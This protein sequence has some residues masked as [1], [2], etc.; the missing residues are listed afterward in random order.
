MGVTEALIALVIFSTAMLGIV[1]T[2]ARVG[3]SLNSSHVRLRALAI[4][5]HQVEELLSADYDA[6][7]N[8]TAEDLGVEM[9]WRVSASS[10]AKEIVLIYKYGIPGGARRDTLTTA[11]LRQ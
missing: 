11:L 8:G 10:S 6:L 3:A 9:A 1:G 5:R 7:A 2:S 4:A